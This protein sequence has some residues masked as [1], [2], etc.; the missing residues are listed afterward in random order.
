MS[1]EIDLIQINVPKPKNLRIIA[2]DVRKDI[3]GVDVIEAMQ[4]KTEV[5]ESSVTVKF[6]IKEKETTHW[7]FQTEP[8]TFHF[9]KRLGCLIVGWSRLK[10]TEHLKATQCFKC[11]HYGHISGHCKNANVCLDCHKGE[12]EVNCSEKR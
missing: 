1:D 12:H 5:E 2:Y 3:K 4:E 7:M 6:P 11:G 10:L 8:K 9:L